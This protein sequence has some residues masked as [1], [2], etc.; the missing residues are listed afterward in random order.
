MNTATRT[1]LRAH[2]LELAPQSTALCRDILGG[3]LSGYTRVLTP[4]NLQ[5]KGVLY[6]VNRRTRV[7]RLHG[8]SCCVVCLLLKLVPLVS[9]T[10]LVYAVLGDQSA[11]VFVSCCCVTVRCGVMVPCLS[12]HTEVHDAGS[13]FVDVQHGTF[14]RC[15]PTVFRF[16]TDVQSTLHNLGV[17]LLHGFCIPS[18]SRAMV[19]PTRSG[20]SSWHFSLSR[21]NRCWM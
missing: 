9:C 21:C 5:G 4:L 3:D 20:N 2:S 6:T 16:N 14:C 15:T 18:P 11:G 12:Q 19:F 7:P 8:L 1:P 10:L 17:Q 13:S